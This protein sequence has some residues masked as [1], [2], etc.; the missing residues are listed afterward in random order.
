LKFIR[1]ETLSRQNAD[2][3]TKQ[4]AFWLEYKG[5]INCRELKNTA[6]EGMLVVLEK[7]GRNKALVQTSSSYHL[8]ELSIGE[9]PSDLRIKVKSFAAADLLFLAMLCLGFLLP[10][11]KGQKMAASTVAARAIRP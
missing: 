4:Q 7:F 6:F 5:S 1:A 9:N 10:G 3:E 8:L 2:I 11:H